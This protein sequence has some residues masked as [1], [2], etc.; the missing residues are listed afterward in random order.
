MKIGQFT[1]Y[2]GSTLSKLGW[3]ESGE[4]KNIGRILL[5]EIASLQY[6]KIL[7]EPSTQL[8][9]NVTV[10]LEEAVERLGR[11]EPLQYVLG[12]GWFYGYRFALGKEVLI[13]RPETEELVRMVLDEI[14]E[15]K[16]RADSVMDLCTGSGCIAWTIQLKLPECR[17]YGC[18]ISEMALK[19]AAS[20]RLA[21]EEAL[22]VS[23]RF[24]KC[25]LLAPGFVNSME[26]S[27]YDIIIANPPYICESE[28]G[29]MRPNVLNYEPEEALFV[30]DSSPLLFYEKIAQSV[31]RLLKPG[32]RIYLEINER[33]PSEVVALLE[34]SALTAVEACN[35]LFGKPR[36]VKGR[37]PL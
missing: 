5:E 21:G 10:R 15:S 18:D 33:F 13:P 9:S 11:G 22:S 16:E 25:N 7:T 4:I 2:L 37:A 31:I 24:F 1:E 27:P 26:G 28:K 35:D 30:P 29:Q 3:Y 34:N 32:G 23:P 19:R 14:S 12:Y 20:Q 36:F 8:P 17:V 6:Y